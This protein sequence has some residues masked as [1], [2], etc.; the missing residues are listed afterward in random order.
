MVVFALPTEIIGTYQVGAFTISYT[1][2]V[3][4]FFNPNGFGMVAVI[5][6]IS[7]FSGIVSNQS[8]RVKVAF[9]SICITC[10]LGVILSNSRLAIGLLVIGAVTYSAGVYYGSRTQT[11]IIIGGI[12]AAVA[13]LILTITQPESILVKSILKYDRPDLWAASVQAIAKRP[14]LGYGFGQAPEAIGDFYKIK[15][16]HN[17]Y[18]NF[19]IQTGSVGLSILVSYLMLLLKRLFWNDDID[20]AVGTLF[21]LMLLQMFF[22]GTIPFGWG[23]FPLMI[24][25]CCG[26]IGLSCISKNKSTK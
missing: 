18:L 2:G 26:Y 4:G 23:V 17:G 19:T 20:P 21:F 9:L 13:F 22:E 25:V 11:G 24:Q 7:S 1:S 5:G 10:I 16:P 14:L 12:T 15:S 8:S 3:A 6:T